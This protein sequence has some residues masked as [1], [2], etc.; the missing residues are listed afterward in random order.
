MQNDKSKFK[1]EF[2]RRVYRFALEMIKFI[3]RLDRV[4]DNFAF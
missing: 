2:K 3:D 4:K 1:D